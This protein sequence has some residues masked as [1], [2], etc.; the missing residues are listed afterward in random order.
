MTLNK[1][2]FCYDGVVGAYTEYHCGNCGS[3]SRAAPIIRGGQGHDA[4]S[5]CQNGI[6]WGWI[7]LVGCAF[8]LGCASR[9]VWDAL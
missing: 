4:E 6:A 8:A 2:V 5:V 7:T 9:I 3:D 1:C